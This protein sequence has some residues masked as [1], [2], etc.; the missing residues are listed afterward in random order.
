ME[1][2]T[3]TV[4]FSGEYGE[5]PLLFGQYF[6]PIYRIYGEQI[7]IFTEYSLVVTDLRGGTTNK[8]LK[9]TQFFH[10]TCTSSNRH[11]PP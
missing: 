1:I 4:A 7:I 2:L 9:G 5:N 6:I 8:P 3:S 10:F 11:P